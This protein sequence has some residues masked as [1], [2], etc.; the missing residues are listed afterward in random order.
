MTVF[1]QPIGFLLMLYST[2]E[3]ANSFQTIPIITEVWVPIV[4]IMV[5]DIL[6]YN[7]FYGLL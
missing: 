5:S 4:L 2:N 1:I 7:K 6:I 3:T